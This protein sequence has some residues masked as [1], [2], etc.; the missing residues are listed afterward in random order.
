MSLFWF[1]ERAP[2]GA[3]AT[4]GCR[5]ILCGRGDQQYVDIPFDR[6]QA[7]PEPVPEVFAKWLC[8]SFSD[9]LNPKPRSRK[10]KIGY[11][12]PASDEIFTFDDG[13][14]HAK[15]CAKRS[16]GYLYVGAWMD[17]ET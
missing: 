10:Q 17:G 14:F 7:T 4:Y 9:W 6:Q 8:G 5:A 1:G 15:A 16:Y 2:E 13:P 3:R 11:V 12:D